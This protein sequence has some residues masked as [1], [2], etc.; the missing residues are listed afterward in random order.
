MKKKGGKERER[1]EGRN[2]LLRYARTTTVYKHIQNDQIIQFVFFFLVC[3]LD[4]EG[5]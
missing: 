4:L 3:E 1:K 5:D 2:D